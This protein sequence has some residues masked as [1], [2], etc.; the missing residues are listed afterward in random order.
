[1]KLFLYLF[2]YSAK[3]L[4]RAAR[5][6]YYSERGLVNEERTDHKGPVILVS[7][8]PG[9]VMDPLNSVVNMNRMVNFLA[10]ASLF[11]TKFSHWFLSTFYCIKIERYVDTGGKPLNNEAAFRQAT[12]FLTGGGCL[13]IAPEGGS[14][15]GRRIQ[16]LKTGLARIALNTEQENDFNLGLQILPIGLNY[17]DPSKFRR[18]ILVIMGEPFPVAIFKKDW[19]EDRRG[20]VRELT[21]HLKQCI[22]DVILNTSDDE[23]DTLLANLEVMLHN[24]SKLPLFEQYKR[25]KMVLQK[26][27]KW[28]VEQQHFIADFS[29]SVG[30]YF[31]KIQKINVE[32][33]SLKTDS[34]QIFPQG[35]LLLLA[36]P[37]A[38]V[39]YAT[40]F[41]PAFLIKKLSEKLSGDPVWAPTYKVAGGLVI[42]PVIILLQIRLLDV[43]FSTFGETGL[44]LKWLYIVGIIPTGL[45]AEW[46]IGKWKIFMSNWRFR[47][48]AKTNQNEHRELLQQRELILQAIR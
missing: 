41:L 8:H 24:E 14:Y 2:Y 42:Y 32:D 40:H 29:E 28:R 4:V 38:L 37:F 45:L 34:Q 7:N 46:F 21:L 44:Y 16:K 9:T 47:R 39:G 23:E 11:N 22:A 43:W 1:M 48:F 36:S 17:S 5:W 6:V 26:I 27:Q 13:Y 33:V 30:T 18:P 10:N 19:E 12:N 35:L 20:A 25:A 31:E 15:E 3:L